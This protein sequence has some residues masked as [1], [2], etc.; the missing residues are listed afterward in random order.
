MH[1]N[2]EEDIRNVFANFS[3]KTPQTK[4]LKNLFFIK[5]F[6]QPSFNPLHL[7]TELHE[8]HDIIQRGFGM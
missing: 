1:C 2:S 3:R 6:Q 4:M 8:Q 5:Y 7:D